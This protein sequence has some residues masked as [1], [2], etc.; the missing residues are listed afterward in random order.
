MVPK[1]TIDA[2]WL[3]TGLGTYTYNLLVELSK[4]RPEISVT[5]IVNDSGADLLAQL[6]H[7]F[8]RVRSGGYSVGEQFEVPKVVRGSDL[9]HATHYNVPVLYRGKLVVT[10]HDLIHLTP[11]GHKGRIGVWAYAAT[12]L[13]IAARKADRII[14][15]SEFTKRQLIERLGVPGPKIRVIPNGVSKQ[16][17]ELNREEARASVC[18]DLK[19]E[20]KYFLCISSLRPHKNVSLLLEAAALFWKRMSVDWDLLIVGKG[21]EQESL[22]RQCERL[23]IEKKVVFLPFIQDS[24]LPQMYAAAEFFVMPSLIEGFGLPVLEAMACG[25]PVAC[26]R[27]ASLPEVGGDAAVYFDPKNSESMAEAMCSAASRSVAVELRRKGLEQAKRFTWSRSAQAHY[28]VY[29]EVLG[30]A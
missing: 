4:L 9:L 15:V 14:T 11:E 3:N 10:I 23:G 7:A 17:C 26:S 12:M 13:R 18:S 20:R 27:S 21:E 6:H 30:C 2:R 22:Q 1:I 29:R 5:A 16:F 28:E 24:L 19:R 25:T 8:I